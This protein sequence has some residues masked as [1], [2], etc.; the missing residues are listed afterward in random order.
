MRL[1]KANLL[2]TSLLLLELKPKVPPS[3]VIDPEEGIAFVLLATNI[4]PE[5]I[6]PPPNILLPA[7]DNIPE[8][9]FF[10]LPSPLIA[11]VNESV[12]FE[13][14]TSIFSVPLSIIVGPSC[15][16]IPDNFTSPVPIC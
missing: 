2:E 10:S 14:L 13:S 6:I 3:K 7:N 4:P 8:P 12:V 9:D 16:E 5:S 1:V 15:V 11:P